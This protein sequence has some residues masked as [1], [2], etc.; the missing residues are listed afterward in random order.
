MTGPESSRRPSLREKL[1]MRSGRHTFGC[2]GSWN[3]ITEAG[4]GATSDG[5][6]IDLY[7]ELFGSSKNATANAVRGP[8]RAIGDLPGGGPTGF[9]R[10]WVDPDTPG[11]LDPRKFKDQMPRVPRCSDRPKPSK[12][13]FATSETD[14]EDRISPRRAESRHISVAAG[15][16]SPAP[17]E[18]KSRADRRSAG[19]GYACRWRRRSRCIVPAQRVGRQARRPR[20][21]ARRFRVRRCGPWSQ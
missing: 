20:S 21:R 11:P 14:T 5:P 2:H 8:A 1:A 19:G 16:G 3:Q 9:A 13:N 6:T 7:G 4:H 18:L 15:P 12:G 10:N 17:P